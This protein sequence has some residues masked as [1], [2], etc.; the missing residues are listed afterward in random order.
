MIIHKNK[1][2]AL[3]GAL[4]F[5]AMLPAPGADACTN[6]IFTK[7]ASMDAST[8]VSYAAESHTTY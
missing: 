4:V 5:A 2:F 7:G 6:I 8:L 3:L 1:T